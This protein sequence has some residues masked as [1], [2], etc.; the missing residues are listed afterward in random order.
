VVKVPRYSAGRR[1]AVAAALATAI[2]GLAAAQGALYVCQGDTTEAAP[3]GLTLCDAATTPALLERAEVDN[4]QARAG[5]L[6]ESV[7]A[8]GVSGRAGLQP[9]DVIYRV[10]GVDVAD[11][12]TAADHL[13]EVGRTSDTIVNFL[14]GGRPY[15]VKLRQP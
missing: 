15:R 14:R 4:L 13:A 5:A 10:G 11:A 9:G 1:L 3:L 7:A 12:A 6:V 8:E 2:P